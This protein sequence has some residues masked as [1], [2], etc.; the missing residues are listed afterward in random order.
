MKIS[1]TFFFVLARFSAPGAAFVLMP[2]M[3]RYM[4]SEDLGTFYLMST[5]LS[6][7][8]PLCSYSASSF[9]VTMYPRY[10][11]FANKHYPCVFTYVAISIPTSILLLIV[12]YF[13]YPDTKTSLLFS[14]F[15]ILFTKELCSTYLCRYQV[16][17][18][19]LKYFLYAS[20]LSFVEVTFV[21]A[22]IIVMS[23]LTVELRFFSQALPLIVL[24]TF[25]SYNALAWL[26]DNRLKLKTI[27]TFAESMVQFHLGASVV[28]MCMP[29]MFG[30][31]K[32][33]VAKLIDIESVGQYGV[34]FQL[35]GVYGILVSGIIMAFMPKISRVLSLKGQ[36]GQY[37]K[38]KLFI[39]YA[40]ILIFLAIFV[41][42]AL[43][44]AG[45]WVLGD[46]VELDPLLIIGFTLG[47]LVFGL[48][49]FDFISLQK[50]KKISYITLSFILATLF[51]VAI[52]YLLIREMG[53]LGASVGTLISCLVLLIF[54]N[55]LNK[56]QDNVSIYHI[57][58]GK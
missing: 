7:C 13:V 39:Q 26:K 4:P 8:L 44:V 9:L 41:A 22:T 24:S 55:V 58:N 1:N 56:K 33:M 29:L 3:T 35:C 40:T 20:C 57:G 18:Q 14:F 47:Q 27:K 48:L 23:K 52:S 21:V 49:Q 45:H 32:I 19:G 5:F 11:S 38:K 37:V 46:N 12:Y 43:V 42:M 16:E 10:D 17:M 2:I 36:R 25:V 34:N 6:I 53:L 28:A 31:D 15:C 54:L 30:A 51:N 50:K